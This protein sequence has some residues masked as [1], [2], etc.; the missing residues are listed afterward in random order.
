MDKGANV[1]VS[2]ISLDRETKNQLGMD[3]AELFILAGLVKSKSEA[4]NQIK[5]GGIRVHDIKIKDPYARVV[6]H[7]NKLFIVES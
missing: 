3:I 5:N 4:R 7:E 6:V 1:I 2:S